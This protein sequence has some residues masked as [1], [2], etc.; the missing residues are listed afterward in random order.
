MGL[1]DLAIGFVLGIIAMVMFDTFTDESPPT[2]EQLAGYHEDSK[3]AL[4]EHRVRKFL[5]WVL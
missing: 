1:V 2:D 3:R 4:R 5:R